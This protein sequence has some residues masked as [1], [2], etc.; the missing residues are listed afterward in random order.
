MNAPTSSVRRSLTLG[1]ATFAAVGIVR[2]PAARA[3]SAAAVDGTR[4]PGLSSYQVGPGDVISVRVFE[5]PEFSLPSVRLSDA[6]TISLPLV[7]EVS[8]MGRT[9]GEIERVLTDRLKGR[10]LVNPIVNVSLLQYRT[11]FIQGQ[12]KGPGTYPFMPG[13]TVRK[14]SVLAGGFAERASMSKIYVIRDKDPG[15][16]QIQA[17]LDT[18]IGPGDLVFVGATFF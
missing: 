2:P 14:A 15:Q 11:F 10:I 16:K 13:L 6:G 9:V 12:V 4:L 1:L 18:E 3:Q 17:N 8:V 7:G 5:E